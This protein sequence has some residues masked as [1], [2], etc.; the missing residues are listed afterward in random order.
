MTKICQIVSDIMSGLNIFQSFI[1]S[2][3]LEKTLLYWDDAIQ[4]R[5][6]EIFNTTEYN[7]EYLKVYG[8]F[9]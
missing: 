1:K 7:K 4:G 5:D 8:Q 6:E 3:G 9:F 2:F